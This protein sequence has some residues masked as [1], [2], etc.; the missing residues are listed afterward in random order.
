[1]V[2]THYESAAE[3]LDRGSVEMLLAIERR[4]EPL[5][6]TDLREVTGLTNDQVR[7]R[8]RK[9]EKKNLIKTETQERNGGRNPPKVHKLEKRGEVLVNKGIG[10]E[11]PSLAEP[12]DF[13]ELRSAVVAFRDELRTLSARVDD[14]EDNLESHRENME[15][16]VGGVT[17]VD[18][19]LQDIKE[20]LDDIEE[21]QG[22][23]L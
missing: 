2:R 10:D 21:D 20:R 4:D 14:L 16:R 23:F 9:L 13:D 6:T 8:R 3:D 15:R 18:E 12:G 5:T 17:G 1:M 11:F 19:E 7:Y 22:G